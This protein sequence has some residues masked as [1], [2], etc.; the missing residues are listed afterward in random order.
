L[1]ALQALGYEPG[2]RSEQALSALTLA[3][4]VLPCVLKLAACTLLYSFWIRPSEST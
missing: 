1:P 2:S 4:C 3:Y